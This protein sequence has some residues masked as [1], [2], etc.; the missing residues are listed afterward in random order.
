MSNL[1]LLAGSVHHQHP[2]PYLISRKIG[3]GPERLNVSSKLEESDH[4]D[5]EI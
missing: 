1:V 3:S 5:K 4:N 2:S